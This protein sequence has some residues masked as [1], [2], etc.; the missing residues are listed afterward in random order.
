MCLAQGGIL[1]A[2]TTPSNDGDCLF[3]YQF[4]NLS[5]SSIL[6]GAQK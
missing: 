2:I 6:A 3:W 4:I 5:S 1:L